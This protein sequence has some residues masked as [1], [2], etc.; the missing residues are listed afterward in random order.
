M[1]VERTSSHGAL[2]LVLCARARRHVRAVPLVVTAGTVVATVT[3]EHRWNAV[4]GRAAVRELATVR[5][6]R[7]NY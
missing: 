4:A 1:L 6:C 7:G 5:C 3:D 2:K